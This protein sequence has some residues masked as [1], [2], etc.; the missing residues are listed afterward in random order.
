VRVFRVL[1]CVLFVCA[2]V[3]T[4]EVVKPF[5]LS[6][7]G[8]ESC[9]LSFFG[10]N[11]GPK[12]KDRDTDKP[13]SEKGEKGEE[14]CTCEKKDAEKHKA[15]KVEPSVE[16]ESPVDVESSDVL[17]DFKNGFAKVAEKALHSVVNVATTQ[18]IQPEEN[19]LGDMFRGFPF[20]DMMKDF[21]GGSLRQA[22]R[23]VHAVGSG[24]IV[25]VDEEKGKAYI[26][27]NHHVVDKAKQVVVSLFDKTELPAEVHAVDRRIDVA[28]LSVDTAILGKDKSKLVAVDWGDSDKLK[29]GNWVVAIGNP[30]GLGN[31][32]TAGIVSWTGRSIGSA[33]GGGKSSLSVVDDFIQHSAPINMGNS[34]GCLLNVYGRVI[35]I[36]NAIF[37]TSGG[38]IG[39]GFAIPSN[40]ARS[41]VDQLIIHKKVSRGWIGVDIHNLTT[42]QGESLGLIKEHLLDPSVVAGA[43][44]SKVV[45]GGPAENGNLKQKDVVTAVDGTQITEKNS[46]QKMISFSPV[47]KPVKLAILRQNDSGVWEEKVVEVVVGDFD[48]AMAKGLIG[49]DDVKKDSAPDSKEEKEITGLGVSVSKIPPRMKQ[50]YKEYSENL[51]VTEIHYTQKGGPVENPFMQ[52]DIIIQANNQKVKNAEQLQTIVSSLT[53]SHEAVKRPVPFIILRDGSLL[54]LAVTLEHVPASH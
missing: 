32:V 16:G 34:G 46:L 21:F 37:S 39:I 53:A 33:G 47:G 2:G 48:E 18:V 54:M 45:P 3:C 20:G 29:V 17:V 51:F 12:P 15:Q 44:V 35:G 9:A 23:K 5:V 1:I 31:T 24:F 13:A 38:N 27:T 14:A 26:V 19:G 28:V 36:N 22:P 49:S 7:L 6:F 41:I 25:K 30:F 43:F 50:T 10:D 40:V 11:S 52:G 4:W 8:S 42:K